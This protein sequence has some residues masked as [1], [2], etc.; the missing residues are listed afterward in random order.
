MSAAPYRVHRLIQDLNRDPKLAATFVS[1]P[2]PVF[3]QY[4]IAENE[5]Q[6]LRD[7]APQALMMLGVHPNLQMK[8]LRIRRAAG[9]PGAGPLASYLRDLGLEP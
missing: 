7:G 8:L 3:E 4:G 1:D 2:E 9:A 6:V 5:R